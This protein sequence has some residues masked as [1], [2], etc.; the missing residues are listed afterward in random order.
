MKT[1]VIILTALFVLSILLMF[2]LYTSFW[3][4]LIYS[5]AIFVGL[6]LI[7]ALMALIFIIVNYLATKK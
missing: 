1:I 2:L 3:V 6:C 5:F 7:A 4:A